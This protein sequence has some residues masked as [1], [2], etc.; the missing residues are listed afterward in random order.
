MIVRV[1]TPRSRSA[2]AW[3]SACSTTAPQ[4]DHE[5]GTAIPPFMAAKLGRRL[6][7]PRVVAR[8]R[9]A[10]HQSTFRPELVQPGFELR[11]A[12]PGLVELLPEP[13]APRRVR[14]GLRLP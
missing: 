4:N 6:R 2:W 11:D 10:E 7:G 13:P 1:S 14:V 12:R 9:T 5:S 3:S 8:A